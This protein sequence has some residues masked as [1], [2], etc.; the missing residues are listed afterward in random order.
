MIKCLVLITGINLIC[1]LEEVSAEIGEPNC[2]I[3]NVYRIEDTGKITKWL[4]FTDQENLMIRSENILT[5]VEPNKKIIK[6]YL[7]TFCD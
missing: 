3:S 2:K 6:S 1:K 7:E 5:I 4:D